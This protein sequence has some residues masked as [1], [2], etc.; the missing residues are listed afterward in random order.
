VIGVNRRGFSL[1]EAAAIAEI[2]E[3]TIRTA[4]EKRSIRPP[5]SRVGKSIRYEFDLNEL[6]F[7]KLLTEFPFSLP[8]E[9]KHSLRQLVGK[10]S[11]SVGRWQIRGPNLLMKKGELSV[12]VHYHPLR[13]QLVQNV[14]LYR[15]GVN[16]IVSDTEILSGERVFKGTRIPLEH[17]AGLFRKGVGEAEIREDYAAL[18]HLDLAFAS[19]HARMSPPPGRPRKPLELGRGKAA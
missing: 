11:G 15:K 16:Q 17:I 12:S 9:D 5:S 1:R 8:K 13:K 7:I 10:S 14:N 6:L 18:S 19:I 2:P 3:S 4:I